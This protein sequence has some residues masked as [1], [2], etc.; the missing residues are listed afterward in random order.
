MMSRLWVV[1]MLAFIL[2]LSFWISH[3]PMSLWQRVQAGQL[4]PCDPQPAGDNFGKVWVCA[5]EAK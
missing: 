3:E 2:A 5:P 4:V 1:A